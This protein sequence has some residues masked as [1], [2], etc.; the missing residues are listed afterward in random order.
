ME[1][2]DEQELKEM[3]TAL[4]GIEEGLND[5]EVDFVEDVSHRFDKRGN[6]QL[7][8]KQAEKV[9]ELHGKHC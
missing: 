6:L 4:I 8:P 3:I 2:S 9:R 7:T 1:P 5:W